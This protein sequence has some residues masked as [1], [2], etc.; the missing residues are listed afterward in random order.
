[1][2]L[3]AKQQEIANCKTRFRVVVAGRRGGKTFL[4]MR[5]LA[6]FASVPNSVVWYLTGS[7]QQAKSLVWSKL[8]KKLK[9]LNWVADTNESELKLEL[10]NGSQICLKS[11]EQGDNLRGESISFICLDE[12]CDLDLDE[13]WSQIIRPSL[14]DK[15]GH[16]LFIGTPKAGNQSARD[17]YD[18]HLTKNNWASFTYTT[19]EGGFVDADEIAQARE[20]LSPKVF[21]QE[22]EAS[23]ENFAGVIFG[24]FGAHNIQEVRK[25]STDHEP[26]YIGNDFNTTPM[27]AVIGRQTKTGIEIFD[28]IYI[29]N[30][31]TTELI[32]EI[33]SRYPKNPII[34]YPDPAGVQRKTSAGGNT[35]IKLLEMAGFQTRYHRQHPLVRDRINAGNSLFFLRPDGTTRFTIDPGC[36]KTIACLKN[37]AYKEGTMIPDKNAGWDHG[38]DALTYMVQYLFPIAKPQEASAPQRFGH[39][40]A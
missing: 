14:A 19:S 5:E 13:I 7:R 36:K 27:S 40:L 23:W 12:F 38:C 9:K 39:A 33:R 22:Y 25:P 30:S 34:I 3:S 35:D 21:K 1:M 6:R 28:E 37:W 15:K 31:N 18:N 26:I 11:A 32:N 29:D 4:A 8:K 16:A 24:D 17:L 10:V 2:P 20:D